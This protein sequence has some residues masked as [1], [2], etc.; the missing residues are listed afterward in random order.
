[1]DY[2]K[3]FSR[4]VQVRGGH[5]RRLFISGTASIDK[6]GNSVYLQDTSAQI[7]RT[8]E[9]VEA[10]LGDMLKCNWTTISTLPTCPI[11]HVMLHC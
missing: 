2:K 11:I 8:M 4:A 3:S 7:N 9:V 1:M 10:I 6:D 5:L